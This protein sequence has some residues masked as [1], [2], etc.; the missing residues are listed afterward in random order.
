MPGIDEAIGQVE[1]LYRAMTGKAMPELEKPYAP[2]PPEADPAQYVRFE[3]ERLIAALHG[4]QRAS[5][6]TSRPSWL[7]RTRPT[8]VTTAP[9][10]GVPTRATRSSL[11]NGSVVISNGP[12]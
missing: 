3:A 11:L 7:S 8:N 1:N 2:I 5:A 6:T 9:S 10:A 4:L 12:N